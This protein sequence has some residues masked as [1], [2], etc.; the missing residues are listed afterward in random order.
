MKRERL[1]DF[2]KKMT[3]KELAFFLK[4][5][6]KEFMPYSKQKIQSELNKRSLSDIHLAKLTNHNAKF[7][8]ENCPRCGSNN[9]YSIKESELRATQY[10]GYEVEKTSKKCRICSY[11][12][13]KDKPISWKVRFYKFLGKYSWKKLK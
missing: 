3:D 7:E 12:A 1:E 6:Y 9:F 13:E 2:L 10:G 11:N 8:L 5:R 4:F